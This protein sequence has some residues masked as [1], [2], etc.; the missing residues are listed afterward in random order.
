MRI[1][2]HLRPV[3]AL[4]AMFLAAPSFAQQSRS[5]DPLGRYGSPSSSAVS[6]GG[7]SRQPVATPRRVVATPPRQ[8]LRSVHDYY[9]GMRPGNGANRNV[10]APGG[11][12]GHVC[13]PGRGRMMG[14]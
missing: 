8:A 1:A 6:R 2:S 3:L 11:R 7:Y 13:V 10:P 5:G 4:G 14:R 12:A 9:P